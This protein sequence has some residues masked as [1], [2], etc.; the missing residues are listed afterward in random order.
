MAQK[1]RPKRVTN[2]FL[3]LVLATAIYLAKA[4]NLKETNLS[5]YFKDIS[6]PWATN[7][8]VIRVASIAN[9]ARIF[10]QFGTVFVTID[11]YKVCLVEKWF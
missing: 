10:I 4:T 6:A 1:F 3:V 2:L 7:A 8:M 11:S 5:L 9:K